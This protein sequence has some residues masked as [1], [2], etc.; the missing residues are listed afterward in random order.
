MATKRQKKFSKVSVV[1]EN[2]RE[3]VGQPKPSF[4]LIPKH[5]RRP[6]YRENLLDLETER[7]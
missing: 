5:K 7:D 2:A 3:R 1:K 4:V 6:K